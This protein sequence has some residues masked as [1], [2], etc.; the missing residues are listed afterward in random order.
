[1]MTAAPA[2]VRTA[3]R[4]EPRFGP[5]EKATVPLP[6]PMGPEPVVTQSRLA[7]AVQVQ[8]VGALTVTDPVPPSGGIE[9][10]PG[11]TD[12]AQAVPV[13]VPVPESGTVVRGL[14]AT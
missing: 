11:D 6:D 13:P 5:I 2:T 7:A 14:P 9:K 3:E 12:C 10:L 1:M 4:G 8:P